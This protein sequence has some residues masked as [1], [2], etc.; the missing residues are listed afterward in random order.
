MG[1]VVHKVAALA[2]GVGG[3]KLV[4]GLDAV[5]GANLS[6]IVNTGDDMRWFGLQI[7]PDLDSVL[8]ALA[9]LTD[10]ARGWGVADESWDVLAALKRLNAPTWFQLGDRDLATHLERTRLLES[11]LTLSQATAELA[12]RWSI[13]S[14]VLPMSD[15]PCTTKV[16]T[17]NGWLSFQEYFVREACRPKVLGLR[18]RRGA[19]PGAA[20]M[21]ALQAADL[22]VIC[23]SNPWLSIAP[24]LALKGVKQV[25]QQKPVIAVSPLIAGQAVKGPAAK[26]AGELGFGATQAAILHCYKPFLD[27][28]VYDHTDPERI[29]PK[30][31]TG[32]IVRQQ[33]TL[34]KTRQDKIALAEAVLDLGAE[35]L[36]KKK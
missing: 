31:Q 28:L 4:L 10:P 6:T 24:I 8:Y 27:A 13:A 18:Y 34:M 11:G 2:G 19:Q 21:A 5:L 29:A 16:Q 30:D 7:C 23:P 22:V 12:G 9:G 36:A 17:E 35:L 26:I 3:A 14:N 1:K 33:Q 15:K 32:I 20:A 25:L